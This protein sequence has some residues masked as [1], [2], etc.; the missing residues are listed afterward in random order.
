MVFPERGVIELSSTAVPEPGPAEL[1]MRVPYVAGKTEIEQINL[2]CH[3]VGTPIEDNWPGVTSLPGYL[4]PTTNIPVRGREHFEAS[5]G[6]VG[7][8]GVDLL[9]RTLTLDPGK[10][11]TAREM[12]EHEWW[13]AEPK[14][15]RKEDLPRKQDDGQ[16]AVDK[17]GADLKR[18]PGVVEDAD[19][20][21]K[22]ARKLEFGR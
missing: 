18:R 13:R 4:V 5:F 9:M 20:V 2:I 1:V 8:L 7:A 15:T 16:D 10:R 19:R 17:M 6:A 3:A 21:G 12:L 14:P 11:I 22:I